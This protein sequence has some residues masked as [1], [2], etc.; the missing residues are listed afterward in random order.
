MSAPAAG[1]TG[2]TAPT[3]GSTE[4]NMA[5]FPRCA[6]CEKEATDS[7]AASKPVYTSDGFQV[8]VIVSAAV[9]PESR[10][11]CRDCLVSVIENHVEV[12]KLPKAE[13]SKE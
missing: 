6:R 1:I 5:Q 8:V 2:L 7:A 4:N 9:Y 12:Y 13:R 11:L 3:E 10:G